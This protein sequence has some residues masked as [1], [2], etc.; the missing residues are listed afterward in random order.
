MPS[1]S[2]SNLKISTEKTVLITGCAGGMGTATAQLLAERGWRVIAVDHNPDRLSR[3][4]KQFPKANH[5]FVK[6]E[7]QDRRI[8][9]RLDFVLEDVARLDGLVNLAGISRGDEIERLCDEDWEQ[10]FVVNATAPMRLCRAA[11]PWLEAAGGAIVNVG[12]P[13]GIIGARK[14]SYAASKAALHGLTM[15]LAR[16]LGPRGIR[17]NLLLPGACFTNLTADWS[18]EKR[19]AVAEGTFLKRLC[20]PDEIASVIGFLLSSEASYLTGS[21]IDLTAGGMWGH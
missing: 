13:V 19:K 4:E 20:R 15:S 14:P 21:V 2:D 3:L 1:K 5:L 10:S 7:L 12:S 8:A 16:N 6:G 17:A 18:E 9:E 11:A